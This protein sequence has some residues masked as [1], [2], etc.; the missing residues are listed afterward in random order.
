MTALSVRK[1]NR[2]AK[3]A[4]QAI[5]LCLCLIF[6]LLL[7]RQNIAVFYISGLPMKASS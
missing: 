3:F 1:L 2:I 6:F 5:E 4:A 7:T